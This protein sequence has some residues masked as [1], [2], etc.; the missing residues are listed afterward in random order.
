M[1]NSDRINGGQLNHQ[2][3]HRRY[4]L[5]SQMN[6]TINLKTSVTILDIWQLKANTSQYYWPL[7]HSVMT[8]KYA[9]DLQW[10]EVHHYYCY[11]VSCCMCSHASL[12]F[13]EYSVDAVIHQ[14]HKLNPNIPGHMF[15]P[16]DYTDHMQWP[17]VFQ[18]VPNIFH[19]PISWHTYSQ[20]VNRENSTPIISICL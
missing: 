1:H 3:P 10:L 7:F 19:W 18:T 4:I 5:Y 9:L 16:L 17:F 15:M 2:T 13:L 20:A 14:T 6:C 8:Q 11:N 12:M